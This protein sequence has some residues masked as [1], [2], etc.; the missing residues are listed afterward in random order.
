[1]TLLSLVLH[2]TH[3]L[4]LGYQA[5]P[6]YG[7]DTYSFLTTL[8]DESAPKARADHISPRLK[9]P[10]SLPRPS[11]TWC[12]RQGL[13]RM[14]TA[15]QQPPGPSL[16][17]PPHS[18]ESAAAPSRSSHSHTQPQAA[19]LRHAFCRKALDPTFL[20][21]S[22]CSFFRSPR[23]CRWSGSWPG[24]FLRWVWSCLSHVKSTPQL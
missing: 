9:V 6:L 19:R 22:P 13:A 14:P 12:G 15:A 5:E 17:P 21:P 2:P 16:P 11:E 7:S 8:Q 24:T 3:R 20:W 23:R 1:M 18:A 4:A 10:Q